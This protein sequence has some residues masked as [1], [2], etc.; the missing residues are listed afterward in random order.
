MSRT[1][2]ILGAAFAFLGVAVGAFGAH[3]LSAT[4]AANSR[5]AT[6]ETAVQ[7]HQLHA[8]ALL[9]AAW[10]A[11]RWPGRWTRWA[12]WLFAVG[13]IIFSGSL[14]ILAIFNIGFMGAITPLGGF[15]F[16]AGWLC[17]GWAAWRS[18]AH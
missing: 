16:L 4:L 5:E 2:A 13:I 11:E 15:T 7:Y 14:Y 17:L 10:A 6:F 3:A 12:G 8:L 18:P 1:F 9:A